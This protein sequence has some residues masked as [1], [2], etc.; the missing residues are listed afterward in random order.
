MDMKLDTTENYKFI[1]H[2]FLRS[3]DTALH[4]LQ[5]AKDFA[6]EKSMSDEQILEAKLAPDMYNFKKQIQIFS[7]NVA[8]A[9]ARGAGLEKPSMPDT[10][11]NLSELIERLEKNILFVKNIDLEKVVNVEDKKIKLPW[12][13]EGMYFEAREYFGNFV[14]QNTLFHLTTAYDIL[15]NLGAQIGKQDFLGPIEMKKEE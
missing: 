6:K 7:D 15:R 12:M 1:Y 10:E 2:V 3:C 14:L 5:K 11:T 4:L 9:I 13:P 8:G